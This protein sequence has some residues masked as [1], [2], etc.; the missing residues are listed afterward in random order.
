MNPIGMLRPRLYRTVVHV[1]FAR[2]KTNERDHSFRYRHLKSRSQN[3]NEKESS[4][5]VRP[6]S[7]IN[8]NT[9]TPEYDWER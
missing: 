5:P 4:E 6:A 9:W 7:L 8:K 2:L 3:R 1:F